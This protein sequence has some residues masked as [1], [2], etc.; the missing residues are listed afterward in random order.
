MNWKLA[1]RHLTRHWRLNLVLL[2]IMLL[3]ASLLA[4]LPMLAITIAGESFSQ[5]LASAPVSERN[6]IIQGKMKH[7]ELSDDVELALDELLLEVIAVREGDFIGFPVISKSDGSEN[8]LYPATLVLNLRSFDRLEDRVRIIE[9]HL[10]EIRTDSSAEN[11]E[12]VL[13]AAVGAEAAQRLMLEVGDEIVSAGG[14]YHLRIVG[15]IEP[16]NPQAEVWWEDEK[17]LA[18]SAWQRISFLPDIEE[19]NLSL[20]VPPQTMMLE[21]IHKHFWRVIL[22]YEKITVLNS[23][24]VRESLI[25]LQSSL[26]EEGMIMRTGL[27]DLIDQFADAFALAQASLLLLTFQSLVAVFFLLGMFGTFFVEQ[28]QIELATLLGRGFSRGQITGLFA[29]SS[30]LISLFAVCLAPWIA[31]WFLLLWSN[32]QGNPAPDFIPVESW[33]LALSTGLFS[34][35]FLVISIFRATR[36]VLLPSQVLR[37]NDRTSIQRHPIWDL[38][39]LTLGGLAYW[40][41]VQ[42]STITR[43]TNKISEGSIT[44]IADPILLLG[45]TLLLLG[46]GLIVIRLLPSLWRFFAWLSLKTRGL[47]W[48]LGFTRLA[49]KPV[50]PNQATTLIS[51]TAGLM[52]FASVFTYSIEKWQQAVAR[53]V[54]G[55]DIRIH[56]SFSEPIEGNELFDSPGINGMTQVIRAETTFLVSDY[57]RL[58]FN[59]LAIDPATFPSVASFPPGF[60]QHSMDRIMGILQSDSLNA[61]PVVIS[62]TTNTRHLTIEDQITLELGK[63]TY[64]FEVVGIIANFPLL[65]DDFVITDLSR[66]TEQINLESLALT[67]QGSKEMWIKVDPS[68]HETIL[69][70]L[71]E[72]GFGDS[73]V[74]N[75]KTKIEDYNNYLVFREAT[76]AFELNALVLIPI[77][78]LG[79]FLMQLFSIQRRTA[80]FNILQA[81]GLSTPSFRSFEIPAQETVDDRRIY[82]CRLGF[83][84]WVGDWFGTGDND[85]ILR[86]T[87][88]AVSWRRLC[89]ESNV[90]QLVICRYPIPRPDWFLWRWASGSNVKRFPKS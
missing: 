88:A 24:D 1:L 86:I 74:G 6:I 41:L 82:F 2:I 36:F 78:G 15:I 17:M 58:D 47:L 9:G 71:V 31:H 34:W 8:N 50:G 72:A 13:E 22:D 81:L 5:T 16:L 68:E 89:L 59:L 37:L 87:D 48:T 76:T 66:F 49:R 79:F 11:E 4:S 26:S 75:S 43:E 73:I 29:R 23:P 55:T 42:G 7:N 40:Q 90:Y 30:I 20:I 25:G 14:R 57:K 64:P 18:F 54:V 83:A 44:G 80:E 70:K 65:D 27:I 53:Y 21:V 38:F 51:L 60:S 12:H 10:P 84:G 85:A 61:L 32:W 28:S 35:I 39:I 67:D 77:S 52:L 19:W 63:E 3:G 33:W 69:A 46:A 56:Q 62:S 45:P